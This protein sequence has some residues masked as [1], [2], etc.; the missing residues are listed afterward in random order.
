MRSWWDFVVET[1]K[2]KKKRKKKWSRTSKGVLDMI[3]KGPQKKGGY[4]NKRAKKTRSAA[5]GYPGGGSIGHDGGGDGGALEEEVE[6]DS[7]DIKDTLEPNIWIDDETINPEVRERLI[8]IALDFMEGL[9]VGA[10]PKDIRLTGSIANYNW[11]DYSDIDLHI[12]VDFSE[13]DDDA[14]LVKKF[15]DASRLR[16]NDRHDIKIFG[17]EVEI[18]VE[19]AGEIHKSSGVYSLLGE[20]WVTMPDPDSGKN[21]WSAIARK[22]SDDIM[23]QIN[24]IQG[25]VRKKPKAALRSIERLKKKISRMRQAGLDSKEQE[26]SV[27]NVIFKILRREGALDLLSDLK[28]RA[29]DSAFSMRQ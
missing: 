29:Y 13:V 22:K 28:D 23:T 17:Y 14:E 21:A 16:W 8:T 4:L 2:K 10:A 1:K 15:F 9:E 3:N 12:V 27:E 24:L 26:Y 25:V 5:P 20:E 6:P 18:Y 19:N 7:F 11:S